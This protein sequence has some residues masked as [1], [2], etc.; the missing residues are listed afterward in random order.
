[1][2]LGLFLYQPP[3]LVPHGGTMISIVIVFSVIK[4]SS[5]RRIIYKLLQNVDLL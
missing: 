2:F 3:L 4:L 1:M 5:A